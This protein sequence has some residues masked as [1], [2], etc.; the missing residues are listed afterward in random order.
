MAERG[1]SVARLA[2]IPTNAE[3]PVPG[4]TLTRDEERAALRERDPAFIGRIE[5]LNE[6]FP[7][8]TGT[9]HAVRRHFGITSFGVNASHA[10]EG[11]PLI[12]PHDERQY[13]QEELYIVL[14]GRARFVCDGEEA[15]L[16][17]HDLLFCAPEVHREAY[18]LETPTLLILVGGLPG[19][20][21]EIPTWSR[22]WAPPPAS[23][24]D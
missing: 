5:K 3:I 21:Y 9:W 19:R 23:A 2:E 24:A 13:G 4:S 10:P 11:E 14:R 18:A 8:L 7:E 17:E 22:D 20:P 1:W 6:R 15:E 16:G 12:V